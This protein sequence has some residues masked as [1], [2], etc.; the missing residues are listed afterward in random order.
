QLIASGELGRLALVSASAYTD[1]LYRPRR[2]EELV[3]DQGGGIMFN[4]VPHQVDAARLVA[5][6]MATSVRAAAWS[7]DPARP[8]E[9]CYAAFVTFEG[10][11]VASLAYSGYDHLDSADLAAGR[12]SEDPRRYGA[13]RRALRAVHG[14]DEEA[15]LR[16]ASGYSAVS[17]ASSESLLQA[18]LG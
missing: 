2:P 4:Q 15:A 11:A 8:T 14:P 6:G 5:G 18:E 13:A 7:L 10:G 3:T 17:P 16:V 12:V 1:F 9:G